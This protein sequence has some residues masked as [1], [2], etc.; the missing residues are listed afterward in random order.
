MISTQSKSHYSFSLQPKH[1]Q[2]RSF[3]SVFEESNMKWL[4]IFFNSFPLVFGIDYCFLTAC[5]CGVTEISC[6]RMYENRNGTF[7]VSN[8]NSVRTI[9]LF[10]STIS[11]L[12][13]IL[14]FKNLESFVAEDCRLDCEK[15]K[16]LAKALSSTNF[17]VW[18]SCPGKIIK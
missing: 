3:V 10:S 8:K 7:D 16:E 11:F 14:D 18:T 4:I 9:S 12:D 13:F 1:L 6:S 5:R 17:D 15:L 2:R